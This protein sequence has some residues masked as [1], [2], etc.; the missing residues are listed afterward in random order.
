MA[1]Q[2]SSKVWPCR[3]QNDGPTR[4]RTSLETDESRFQNATCDGVTRNCAPPAEGA[5]A[6]LILSNKPN[7]IH[8]SNA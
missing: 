5:A 6:A 1:V 8:L 7:F 2:L 3:T 4:S